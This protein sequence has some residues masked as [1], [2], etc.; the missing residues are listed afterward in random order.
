MLPPTKPS[1]SLVV[2]PREGSPP[3]MAEGKTAAKT[4]AAGLTHASSQPGAKLMVRTTCRRNHRNSPGCCCTIL[5]HSL[6]R[7]NWPIC[8]KL[9]HS[10]LVLLLVLGAAVLASA[11]GLAW[12]AQVLSL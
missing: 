12:V 1:A 10:E 9:A 5:M 11:L 4:W 2:R 8:N 7:T 6:H 3:C